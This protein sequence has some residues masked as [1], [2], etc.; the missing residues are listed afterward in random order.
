[1][2]KLARKLLLIGLLILLWGSSAAIIT[3]I[4]Y[5]PKAPETVTKVEMLYQC[6]EHINISVDHKIKRICKDFIMIRTNLG[7]M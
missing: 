4:L 1:M 5:K 6:Q 7:A 2:S 3:M